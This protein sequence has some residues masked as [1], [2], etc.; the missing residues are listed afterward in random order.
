MRLD[1]H[2]F[3]NIREK[4]FDRT[5]RLAAINRAEKPAIHVLKGGK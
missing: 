5:V 1:S 3:C 4:L 2:A